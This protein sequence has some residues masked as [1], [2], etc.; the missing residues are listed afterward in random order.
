MER[1]EVFKKGYF[2]L[3]KLEDDY[4]LECWGGSTKHPDTIDYF[5]EW[6]DKTDLFPQELQL[7]QWLLWIA[8]HKT[9]QF[10]A[11]KLVEFA[12]QLLDLEEYKL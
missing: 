9:W 7:Y 2:R 12:T 1:K 11:I 4:M 5:S 8:S 6:E 3:Y 10:H